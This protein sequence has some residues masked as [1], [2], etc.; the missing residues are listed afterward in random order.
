MLA[1]RPRQAVGEASRHRIGAHAED[2]RN[3]Q[4]ERADLEGGGALSY[5]DIDRQPHQLLGQ[6]WHALD[7]I[8]AVAELKREVAALDIAEVS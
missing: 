4:P 3:R 7:H 2:D 5:E 1:T 8:V 6:F